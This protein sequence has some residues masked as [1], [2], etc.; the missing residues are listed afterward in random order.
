MTAIIIYN[1]EILRSINYMHSYHELQKTDA[2]WKDGTEASS[3]NNIGPNFGCNC[4]SYVT[5]K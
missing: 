5:V 4:V 1:Y 2:F 3:H